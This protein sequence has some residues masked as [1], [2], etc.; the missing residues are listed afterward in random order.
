MYADGKGGI[1]VIFGWVF[2]RSQFGAAPTFQT[3]ATTIASI[4]TKHTYAQRAANS[5][6]VLTGSSTATTSF[7]YRDVR[8][9]RCVDHIAVESL[10]KIKMCVFLGVSVCVCVN[11][12]TNL[13][14]AVS[15][16]LSTILCIHVNVRY[17]PYK[18]EHTYIDGHKITP[19]MVGQAKNV[20]AI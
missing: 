19:Q 16:W 20:Y 2:L 15:Q 4:N 1:Y 13:K 11:Q 7:I 17:D 9:A 6:S 12:P 14:S 8:C 3:H 18:P 5:Q 10:S